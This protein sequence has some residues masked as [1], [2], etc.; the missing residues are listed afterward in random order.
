MLT[1]CSASACLTSHGNFTH[2]ARLQE[3]SD[4]IPIIQ[5][6]VNHAAS[7]LETTACAFSIASV[8]PALME[9]SA[10]TAPWWA[11]RAQSSGSNDWPL[12]SEKS[13][14][15]RK[16]GDKARSKHRTINSSLPDGLRRQAP[17]TELILFCMLCKWMLYSPSYSHTV[18]LCAWDKVQRCSHWPECSV[19]H[20]I[21]WSN[22]LSKD[23]VLIPIWHYVGKFSFVT[24]FSWELGKV[25]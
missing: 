5:G 9:T 8:L 13:I 19:R 14:N 17:D 6:T 23:T 7:Y 11:S 15:Q 2:E 4:S 1:K 10:A 20:M 25:A 24:C 22:I 21:H 12:A 18:F 16:W 3:L